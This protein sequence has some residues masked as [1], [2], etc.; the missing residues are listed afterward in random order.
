VRQ[1]SVEAGLPHDGERRGCA[2]RVSGN[3][4]QSVSLPAQVSFRIELEPW[5]YQIATNV[6]LDRLRQRQKRRESNFDET[7]PGGDSPSPGSTDVVSSMIAPHLSPERT[8]CGKEIG[9]QIDAAVSTLSETERL[10]FEMKHY[11]GLKLKSIGRILETTE[12]AAK[13]YLF[14][15]TRKLRAQL[16]HT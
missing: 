13:N 7:Y 10:V 14:R 15:A 11:G 4:S 16:S 1:G 2:G 3:V 8:L 12:G 9:Q 6:C 5:L